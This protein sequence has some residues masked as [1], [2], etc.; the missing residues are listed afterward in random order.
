MN[1]KMQKDVNRNVVATI[2]HNGYKDVLLNNNC[3]RHSM[4]R[5]Q[6]KDHRIGTY[7]INKISLTCFDDKLCIQQKALISLGT[8]SDVVNQ[9]RNTLKNDGA[10]QVEPTKNANTFKD[11]D[12]DLAE[13]LV[14]KLSVALNKF[15]NNLTKQYY[16]NIEESGHNFEPYNVTMETIKNILAFLDA[17]KDPG[18]D[19]RFSEFSKESGEGLALPLCILQT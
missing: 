5:I 3:I 4:N 15:N 10:I 9:S 19:K 2:C 16:M 6:S 13:N 1:T 12:S 8:K 7:E 17:S 11:F 14:R 18:L